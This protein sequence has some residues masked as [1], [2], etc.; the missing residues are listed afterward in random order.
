MSWSPEQ[1][2]VVLATAEGNLILMTREFDPL[3]ETPL[4]PAE[5]GDGEQTAVSPVNVAG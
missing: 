5:F 1:D 4:C 3:L 2:L